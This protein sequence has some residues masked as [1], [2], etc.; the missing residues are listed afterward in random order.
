MAQDEQR[1]DKPERS[2]EHQRQQ[3]EAREQQMSNP[4]RLQSD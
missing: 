2:G 3:N 4:G 1:W